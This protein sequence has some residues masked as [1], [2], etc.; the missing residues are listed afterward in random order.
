MPNL[1]FDLDLI[2]EDLR[3]QREDLSQLI[4][5]QRRSHGTTAELLKAIEKLRE[6]IE[7]TQQDLTTTNRS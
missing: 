1:K 6:R 2:S 3:K 5:E 4:F 7:R